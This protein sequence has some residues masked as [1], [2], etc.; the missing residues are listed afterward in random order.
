MVVLVESIETNV[1]L[2]IEYVTNKMKMCQ[3]KEDKVSCG[4]EKT[5]KNRKI[6]LCD[7]EKKNRTNKE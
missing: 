4:T 7:R 2:Q 3:T 6:K 5:K 1:Y